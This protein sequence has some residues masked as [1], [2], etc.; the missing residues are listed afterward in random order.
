M[1]PGQ[2]T[3]SG[4]RKHLPTVKRKLCNPGHLTVIE[5]QTLINMY[6]KI[7][8]DNSKSKTVNVVSEIASVVGVAK[9]TVYRIIKEYKCT[10]M[11]SPS[12]HKGGRPALVKNLDES[13]KTIIRQIVN[14]FFSRNEIPTLDK[15]L[16]EVNS[17][18]DLPQMSRSSL[19]KFMKQINFH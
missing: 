13:T 16:S 15:V 18:P 7:L 3:N 2:S 9:S 12:E 5:K 11:V 6:K 14:S 4:S 17:R 10:K 19:Y 8:T 1:N